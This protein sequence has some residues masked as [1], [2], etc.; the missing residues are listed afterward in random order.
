[1]GSAWRVAAG[2]CALYAGCVP[3]EVTQFSLKDAE[4]FVVVGKVAAQGETAVSGIFPRAA[5]IELGAARLGEGIVLG[6]KTLPAG[7]SEPLDR[8]GRVAVDCDATLPAPDEIIALDGTAPQS[9]P[10]ITGPWLERSDCPPLAP[11]LAIDNPCALDQ[12]SVIITEGTACGFKGTLDPRCGFGAPV[13]GRV[14]RVGPGCLRVHTPSCDPD[15]R[16]TNVNRCELDAQTCELRGYLNLAPLKLERH[17][18]VSSGPLFQPPDASRVDAQGTLVQAGIWVERLNESMRRGYASDLIVMGE[19]VLTLEHAAPIRA[20]SCTAS[21]TPDLLRTYAL[22]LAPLSTTTVAPCAARLIAG[23]GTSVMVLHRTDSPSI[24]LVG[25]GPARRRSLVGS[26]GCQFRGQQPV[27]AVNRDAQIYVL[28]SRVD[29]DG[30]APTILARMPAD[31]SSPPTCVELITLEHA[32]NFYVGA[33]GRGIA[34]DSGVNGIVSF[35]LDGSELRPHKT[36][37]GFGG[38]DLGQSF[39]IEDELIAAVLPARQASI[40]FWDFRGR[41][42]PEPLPPAHQAAWGKGPTLIGPYVPGQALVALWS[43]R[44]ERDVSASLGLLKGPEWRFAAVDV[45]L[46][47]GVVG[48]IAAYPGGGSLVLMPWTGEVIRVLP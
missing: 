9:A 12:C 3:T 7:L 18:L 2:T 28:M 19:R 41:S 23:P 26:D 13:S 30:A 1:M 44:G 32:L 8:G 27:G 35:D 21:S 15:P 47:P 43:P 42:E 34:S 45:E 36:R 17:A 48:A 6:W 38:A 20:F 46:G 39:E 37:T 40:Q 31:L 24:S 16:L 14:D 4:W 22:D 10:L 29:T 25:S 5:A 11:G 33:N